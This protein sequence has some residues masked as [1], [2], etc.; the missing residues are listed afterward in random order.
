MGA[1]KIVITE[2]NP[3]VF[4]FR[5]MRYLSLT[6]SAGSK[7]QGNEG[8]MLTQHPA[9]RELWWW[10]V[11]CSSLGIGKLLDIYENAHE[12]N[13]MSMNNLITHVKKKE[14]PLTWLCTKLSAVFSCPKSSAGSDHK[15]SHISPVVGGSLNLSICKAV[16]DRYHFRTSIALTLR[17]SSR[18][19]SSGDKPPWMQRNCLFMIAAKGREQNDSMQ[20]S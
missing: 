4:V 6:S 16:L 3:V 1:E 7:D 5:Y 12:T 8:W 9:L 15:I 2:G 18:V 19:F 10:R 14:H 13:R 11:G 20:A 17:K